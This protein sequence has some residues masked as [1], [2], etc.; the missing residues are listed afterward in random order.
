MR[1][2]KKRLVVFICSMLFLLSLPLISVNTAY[3][4]FYV[5]AHNHFYQ[6]DITIY[7]VRTDEVVT[8]EWD[9]EPYAD[10]YEHKIEWIQGD[11]VLQTYQLG[12]T[13]NAQINITAPRAGVFVISGRVWVDGICS[14][15][16]SSTDPMY[17][18]VDGEHKGWL[19]IFTMAGP[20]PIIIN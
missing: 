2:I 14:D 4:N 9:A 17:A 12:T 3:S 18:I 7:W 13:T 19:I 16:V 20:G 15:W 5:Y 8:V 11:K 10:Y 6:K 1:K